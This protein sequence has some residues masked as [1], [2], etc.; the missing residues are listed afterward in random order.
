MSVIHSDSVSVFY[1]SYTSR[2]ILREK[3]VGFSLQLDH[4]VHYE[5]PYQVQAVGPPYPSFDL[6]I[7][8]LN[9]WGRNFS[10]FEMT[11][12]FRYAFHFVLDS[13]VV[14]VITVGT[15]NCIFALN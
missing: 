5:K 11:I 7:D 9:F 8:K 4:W 2:G 6:D 15:F 3:C 13:G 12:C 1:S 14:Y 10:H